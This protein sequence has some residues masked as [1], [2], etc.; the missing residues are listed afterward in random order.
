MH[1]LPLGETNLEL[2]QATP[3]R[4]VPTREH[5]APILEAQL[6]REPIL[7]AQQLQAPILEAQQLR[8]PILGDHQ[9]LVCILAH[10]VAIQVPLGPF[11]L[12]GCI[13]PL[14]SLQAV[15]RHSQAHP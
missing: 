12:E 8:V 10:Q 13:L 11:H 4:L 9:Y 14:D 3:E 5:R 2:S 15:A 6:L 7:E 1:S